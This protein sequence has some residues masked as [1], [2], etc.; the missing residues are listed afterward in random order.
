MNTKEF[1]DNLIKNRYGSYEKYQGSIIIPQNSPFSFTSFQNRKKVNGT[2]NYDDWTDDWIKPHQSGEAILKP[3][4][5]KDYK[6]LM[7]VMSNR[8]D[9]SVAK[10][11]TEISETTK[12]FNSITKEIDTMKEIK[13]IKILDL[14]SNKM[15]KEHFNSFDKAEDE[16]L[17]KDPL[18]SSIK[19]KVREI[20]NL[21]IKHGYDEIKLNLKQYTDETT[22]ELLE[23]LAKESLDEQ[24]ALSDK[25]FEIKSMLSACDTYEQ[26]MKVLE[27][28]GVVKDGKLSI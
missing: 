24:E 20:N 10:I 21:I 3:S 15:R 27:T 23:H 13:T 12:G 8:I 4:Q 28:Y 25:I 2:I 18:Y 22:D 6:D 5:V 14:Y 9:A 17:N 19:D 11:E 26:E 7:R 16:I 1:T